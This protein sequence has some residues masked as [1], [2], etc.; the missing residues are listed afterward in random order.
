[1][2]IY[3]MIKTC[4]IFSLFTG[5]V[6]NNQPQIDSKKFNLE[7][8]KDYLAQVGKD[9][10]LYVIDAKKRDSCESLFLCQEPHNGAAPRIG[11]SAAQFTGRF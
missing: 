3:T 4:L 7:K 6:V 2:K 1:M 5:C 8:N 10:K 11:V 9:N